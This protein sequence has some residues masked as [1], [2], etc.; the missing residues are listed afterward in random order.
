MSKLVYSALSSLDG[1][2]EDAEGRFDWAAP[3]DEVH[4]FVNDLERPIATYLYGRRMYETMAYWESPANTAD[5]SAVVQEYGKIWRAADKVV[6]SGTLE[7]VSSAA[8]RIEP[9][10][11]PAAVR[12][13]KETGSGDLSIGGPELAAH[14]IDGGLVDEYHL[15]LAPVV[16]GAGK[17]ALPNVR[18]NLELLD[19]RRFGNGTVYLRYGNSR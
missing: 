16:V 18:L 1:Y 17:R 15:F 14:A 10:F 8:T 4:A 6:Y 2:I 11:D 13:L 12:R 19:E 5:Q 3:D 9:E 7:T